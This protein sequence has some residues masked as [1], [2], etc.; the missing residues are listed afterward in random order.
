MSQSGGLKRHGQQTAVGQI[1]PAQ[2]KIF[3]RGNRA[4]ASADRNNDWLY[5][6]ADPPCKW[7]LIKGI[8][9]AGSAISARN[10]IKPGF[11][12]DGDH[13]GVNPARAATS[14]GRFPVYRGFQIQRG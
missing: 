9:F 10:V 12:A 7:Q 5:R 2:T 13:A 1:A 6:L 4:R 14:P 3:S 8:C 11:P